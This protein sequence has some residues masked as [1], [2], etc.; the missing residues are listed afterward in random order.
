MCQTLFESDKLLFSFLLA[1]KELE[2]E[3]KIDKRQVEFFIKGALQQEEDIFNPKMLFEQVI[4]EKKIKEKQKQEEEV[5]ARRQKTCPWITASQ[6]KAIDKLSQIPPF[7]Q[8]NLS[9][10]QPSLAMHIESNAEQWFRY[11][12]GNQ[13]LDY[14]MARYTTKDEDGNSI[15]SSDEEPAKARRQSDSE[16]NSKESKEESKEKPDLKATKMSSLVMDSHE[17]QSSSIASVS[18]KELDSN[19]D[20][21]KDGRK[22]GKHSKNKKA[23]GDDDAEVD[24]KKVKKKVS[25]EGVDSSNGSSKDSNSDLSSSSNLSSSSDSED[26]INQLVGPGVQRKITSKIIRRVNTQRFLDLGVPGGYEKF[27]YEDAIKRGMQ[28]L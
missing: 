17:G 22:T 12:N 26:D 19:D 3:F 27:N 5:A 20:G 16:E 7:N 13:L 14:T 6:W 9:N 28:Q 25:M 24:G 2:V 11:I 4:D 15:H 8:P 10:N 21:S 18:S 23:K 1:Y